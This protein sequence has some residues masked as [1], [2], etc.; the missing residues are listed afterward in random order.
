[1]DAVDDAAAPSWWPVVPASVREAKE[2]RIRYQMANKQHFQR[3]RAVL[4]ERQVL[5]DYPTESLTTH[6]IIFTHY[7]LTPS[8][9]LSCMRSARQAFVLERIERRRQDRLAHRGTFLLDRCRLTDDCRDGVEKLID[10]Y[11]EAEKAGNHEEDIA[12]MKKDL[13]EAQCAVV[14]AASKLIELCRKHG[15]TADLSPQ[16]VRTAAFP[17]QTIANA[18]LFG[19]C[20]LR[21]LIPNPKPIA[22]FATLPGT[23]KRPLKPWQLCT[24][25]VR[26]PALLVL[27]ICTLDNMHPLTSPCLCSTMP[28]GE[29]PRDSRGLHSR[30]RGDHRDLGRGELLGYPDTPS[31]TLSHILSYTLSHPSDI[32]SYTLTFSTPLTVTPSSIAG[33]HP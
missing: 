30:L 5:I 8:L 7:S 29:D 18:D 23:D 11:L 12:Y 25:E 19:P 17:Y 9:S 15:L 28:T 31:R 4:E 32:L 21:I 20:D 16:T 6:P 2:E 26:G 3:H 10:A 24:E 1:M 27:T 33:E 14:M 13:N 22:H